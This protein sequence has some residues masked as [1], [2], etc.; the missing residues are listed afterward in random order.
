MLSIKKNLLSIFCLVLALQ[1]SAQTIPLAEGDAANNTF[2][3]AMPVTA[4]IKLKGNIFPNADV[5]FYSFS[6]TA[7]DKVFA[8]VMTSFS[9]S[10]NFSGRMTLIGSDG[11]TILETDNDNGTFGATAGSLAGSAIPTTG[12]YYIR[13]ENSSVTTQTRGYDLYLNLQQ[14]TPTSEIEPNDLSTTATV[15]PANGFVTGVKLTNTDIDYYSITLAAGETVFISLD[16]DPERDG[17]S[18]NGI[19]GVGPLG[20]ANNQYL[21]VNDAGSSDARPSEAHFLTVKDAGT[22]YVFVDASTATGGPTFTYNLSVK[23]FAP[24]TGYV[25]YSSTDVPKAIGPGTGSVTSTITIPDS[26][27]IGD[28]SVRLNLNH[29]LMADIDATL[30]T[31]TGEVIVLF[32]DIAPTAAGGQQI[33][34]L[35]LNDNNAT[36]PAFPV[37]SGMGYQPEFNSKLAQLQNRNAAGTWTLTLYDDAAN[38]SGGTLNNWSIDILEKIAPAPLST[39]AS[40]DFETTDGGFTHS[41]IADAWAYGTPATAAGSGIAA[42]T[43]ANSGTKCWKTNLTGVYNVSSDQTLVS[44]IY[45][46][47]AESGNIVLSYAMKY[48]IEAAQFD[49]LTVY[50][51]EEPGGS[52]LVQNLFTWLGATQNQSVGNPVVNMGLSGGWANYDANVSAFAGKRFRFK[53]RLQTDNSVQLSGVAIDDVKLFRVTVLSSNTNVLQ[54]SRNSGASKLQW[55]ISCGSSSSASITLERSENGI[56]FTELNTQVASN[57]RCATPFYFTDA[58]PFPGKNYYRVKVVTL[59]GFTTYTNIVLLTHKEKNIEL[60]SISPNPVKDV[61]FKLN[62]AAV[63]AEAATINVSDVNGK[64][65]SR[66]NIRLNV[67]FNAPSIYASGLSSGIYYVTLVTAG[68][69][70]ETMKMVKQ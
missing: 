27:L 42:F 52:G 20:D 58:I 38:T 64:V 24:Q 49:N 60:L 29:A 19:V 26:K 43:T 36:P 56:S 46:L 41:G 62:I 13:I 55:Q 30:T 54:G 67:G 9:A 23:K 45:D 53:V 7:G 22:Y 6:A 63:K 8:S 4:P 48:S 57:A 31:P 68:G 69:Y 51:E 18:W 12:T 32:S 50:A 1:V 66:Q 59:T 65:V 39:I 61:Q 44:P 47:T 33:M 21:F 37:I 17:V 25:N 16:L 11:S 2:S 14:G 70:T 3:T 5:D 40:E 35:F 15:F 34:N 10:N 28:I